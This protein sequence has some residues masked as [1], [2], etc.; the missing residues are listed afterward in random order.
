MGDAFQIE[1][2]WGCVEAGTATVEK[3]G[4]SSANNL[5]DW[6]SLGTL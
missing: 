1:P 5:Y 2:L 4:R 3:D 6:E